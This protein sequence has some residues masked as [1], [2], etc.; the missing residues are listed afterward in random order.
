MVE[1]LTLYFLSFFRGKKILKFNPFFPRY[2]ARK[3]DY[4]NPLITQK[5]AEY[6]TLYFLT[7]LM[8]KK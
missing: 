8:G 6:L 1:F 7:F 2:F 4:F 3:Y 5:M